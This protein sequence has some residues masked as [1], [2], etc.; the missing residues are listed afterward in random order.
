MKCNVTITDTFGG[1]ANYGWVNR[2]GFELPNEASQ[3]TIT[4]YAK[5]A[6]GMTNVKADTYDYGESLTIKPR[7][8]NQVIF[9]DFE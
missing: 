4:Y 5:K 8:Y 7:G 9:V 1:E 3:R 6:A 2:Y